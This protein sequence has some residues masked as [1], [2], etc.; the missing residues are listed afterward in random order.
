MEMKKGW[1]SG[2]YDSTKQCQVIK[3][4]KNG[5]LQYKASIRF[6]MLL[7]DMLVVTDAQW[8]DG[9]FFA[10]MALSPDN[11]FND[12]MDFVKRGFE[13]SSVPFTIRRRDNYMSMFKKRF[14][15]SSIMNEELQEFILN[16]WDGN[17]SRKEEVGGDL[18]TFLDFICQELKKK[19]KNSLLGDFYKFGAGIEKLDHI[20]EKLFVP[21]GTTDYI[22][23]KIKEVRPELQ[24]QLEN[25]GKDEECISIIN[26]LKEEINKLYP[27]RSTIKKM[28][29][30]LG[31]RNKDNQF[32]ERFMH[33]FDNAYNGA[34]AQQHHCRYYDLYDAVSN[35]KYDEATQSSVFLDTQEFPKE[36]IEYLGALSWSEFG[37][38]YYDEAVKKKRIQ[39]LSDFDTQEA[40]KA[41]KSFYEYLECIMKKMKDVNVWL[42]KNSIFYRPTGT[43]RFLLTADKVSKMVGGASSDT[44]LDSDEICLFFGGKLD[45]LEKN[46]IVRYASTDDVTSLFDTVFA[47]IESLID[48]REKDKNS[49][50]V[51]MK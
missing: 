9:A 5:M 21:W 17:E 48:K 44:R 30:Q 38:I 45:N 19:G 1:Y 24:E 8:Y 25:K 11:E 14:S 29:G 15:F 12:F 4:S 2:K 37:E 26:K 20:D 16:I 43:T 39:W 6:E 28:A 50:R 47:P 33:V 32:E 10:G 22:P 13:S 34:I 49:E 42:I 36:F 31:K 7:A 27:N 46:K 35:V 3:A 41:K 23:E 40:E 18:S 51:S